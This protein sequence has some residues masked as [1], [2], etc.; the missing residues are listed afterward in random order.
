ME[1]QAAL[2][3]QKL[4]KLKWDFKKLTLRA[5]EIDGGR[6]LLEE[7][8]LHPTIT[9]ALHQH[10]TSNMNQVVASSS[11]ELE[12]LEV[13]LEKLKTLYSWKTPSSLSPTYGSS[14]QPHP[15]YTE[16]SLV[17]Y[18]AVRVMCPLCHSK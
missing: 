7:L 3:Q 17:F 12:L 16:T 6:T 18:V 9:S 8:P 1:N 5:D 2:L 13:L 11:R 14:G 4:S 10:T 15:P